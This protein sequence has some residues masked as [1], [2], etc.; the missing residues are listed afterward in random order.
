MATLVALFI[1]FGVL[2][3]AMAVFGYVWVASQ[4]PPAEELRSRSLRFATTQILDRE[5]N[6]LWEIIDP[7]GGGG[8]PS[9]WTRFRLT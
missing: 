3:L 8:P 5:G 4:L 9:G 7:S 1:M 6:L 2:A